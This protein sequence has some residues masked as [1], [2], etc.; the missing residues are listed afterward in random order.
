MRVGI[1]A[2]SFS[3]GGAERQAALWGHAAQ[4]L[5]HEVE[6][7]AFHRLA[8]E[9]AL[10][11]RAEVGEAGKR[12]Q[13]D[14]VRTARAVRGLA[15][16]VDVVAAFQPYPAL[17][18]AAQ[19]LPAPWLLVSGAD[20]RRFADTSR[21]PTGLFRAA[22]R[23]AAV[24]TAPTR[25]LVDCYRALG[26]GREGWEVVPNVAAAEA[27]TTPPPA[28]ERGGALW[29]G[30]LVPEKD[31]ALAVR[32]ARR[33]G[34]PLTIAGAGRLRD[35]VLRLAGDGV[36]VLDYTP[37]PWDLYARHRAFLLTSRYEAFGNVIVEALAAGMPVVAGDCDFGP[38]EVLA[39]ATASR[40]VARDEHDLAAALA[41][42]AARPPDD[43][44]VRECREIAGRYSLE[45]LTPLIGRVLARAAGGPPPGAPG[46]L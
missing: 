4:A 6:L 15:R 17:F 2:S 28:E 16:R 40:V 36:E 46:P 7:L 29:L 11:A 22:V 32:A 23:R 34:V 13:L 41:E 10:P 21:L 44:A 38:R 18:C 26:F 30:R 9:Y 1:V 8:G 14:L 37:E 33:A 39:G 24:R 43:A 42:V 19:P 27:F 3:L 20:P 31:P 5:G 12:G 45:A 25:G 35:E